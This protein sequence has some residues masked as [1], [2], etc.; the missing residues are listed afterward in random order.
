MTARAM[1]LHDREQFRTAPFVI[2]CDCSLSMRHNG[3]LAALKSWFPQ[4][5]SQ[6]QQHPRVTETAAMSVV[7]FSARAEVVHPLSYVGQLTAE[8]IRFETHGAQTDFAPPMRLVDA[9]LRKL[10]G[11][12]TRSYPPIVFWLSDGHH[13]A[14]DGSEWRKAR[15]Q[16]I[17]AETE[18]QATI[19]AFGMGEADIGLLQ[20]LASTPDLARRFDQDAGH[21][22]KAVLDVILRSTVEMTVHR[23]QDDAKTVARSEEELAADDDGLIALDG[24]LD[25]I[26]VLVE[27]LLRERE[28]LDGDMR[29]IWG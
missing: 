23:P 14:G 21:A 22:I 8:R 19:V 7:T 18:R 15:A 12:A 2:A 4:L 6:L 16:L 17:E 9:E 20:E 24:D 25:E 1:I 5:I 10:S 28:R 26:A 29:V 3:G 13:N 27:V 11:L